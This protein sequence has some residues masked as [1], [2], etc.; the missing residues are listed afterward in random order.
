MRNVI[1]RSITVENWKECIELQV[2]DDQKDFIPSNLHSIAEAQ[3]YPRAVSLAIYNG[4]D[5]M[6]GFAMY[7]VDEVSGKWKVFRM[8]IDRAHQGNGYG[9]AAMEAVIERLAGRPDCDEIL[10]AYKLT[11]EAARELYADLGF[12][13]Q[14]VSDGLVRAR[15]DL[16]KG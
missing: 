3:F 4:E 13:E 1:L 7:G 15:L 5:Q 6:V 9:R 16:E 14:G 10:I 2:C 8:M 11:N 12:V